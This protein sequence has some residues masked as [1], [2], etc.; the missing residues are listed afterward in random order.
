MKYK[1]SAQVTNS[2]QDSKLL[3][4]EP[5]AEEFEILSG[6]TFKF[7]GESEKKGSFEVEF[8]EDTIIVFGWDGSTVKVFCNS[9]Q[10]N[11]GASGKIAVPIFSEGRSFSSFV[12]SM[13]YEKK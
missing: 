2:A 13:F 7:I 6:E 8:S 9:E 10:I 11:S 12:K 3:I 4:L 5:W 1:S